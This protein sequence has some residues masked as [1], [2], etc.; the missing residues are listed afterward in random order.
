MATARKVQI[1]KLTPEQEARMPEWRDRWISIGLSTEPADRPKFEAAAARCYLAAG[2]AP[3]K[4]VI[5]V[6]SP[7]ALCLAA[8]IAATAIELYRGKHV[9]SAVDSAVRS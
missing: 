7:I 3:P 9:R 5:W 4:R 6:E 2:L 1:E 8:P